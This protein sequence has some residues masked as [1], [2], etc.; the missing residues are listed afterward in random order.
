MS[1]ETTF[2]IEH[3]GMAVEILSLGASI[4]SLRP[5]GAS[6]SMI[7]GLAADHYGAGNSAY[8]GA[9]VGR[10]ANRIAFGRFDLGGETYPLAINEAP[11]QLHGGPGGF[12]ARNWHLQE[13]TSSRLV[14]GLSS[15][16]G[17]QGFPGAVE[18]RA[19]FTILSGNALEI[20]YEATTDRPTIVNLTSHLYFNLDG[21]GD[22]LGHQLTLAADHYLPVN[23]TTMPTGEITSVEG[24]RYDFRQGRHLAERPEGLDHNFCLGSGRDSNLRPAAKLSSKKSGWG[25]ELTTTEPGLQV[26]DG[27]KLTG[28]QADAA[29]HPIEAFAGLA[30]EPQVW[31]DAPNQ[32]NFPSALLLPGELYRNVSRYRFIARS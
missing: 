1:E 26:Y 24:T 6:H 25:L 22:V 32:P 14:L 20:A 3:D 16:D 12:S 19:I 2:T 18:A 28:T 27:A 5:S 13:I 29:G 30:L 15:H 9:S 10:F 8:I 31:P 17:D 4:S 11:H 7:L 21:A 23:E